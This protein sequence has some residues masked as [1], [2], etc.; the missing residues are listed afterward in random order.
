MAIIFLLP[1]RR[2]N[3]VYHCERQGFRL[4]HFIFYVVAASH[5]NY[6]VRYS[7]NEHSSAVFNFSAMSC[8]QFFFFF[9]KTNI[10]DFN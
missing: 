9:K 6:E 7:D 3:A 10:I 4:S 2:P 8:R 1:E 5:M